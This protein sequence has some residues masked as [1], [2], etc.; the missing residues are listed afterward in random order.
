[1]AAA[2]GGAA[3]LRFYRVTAPFA[4]VVIRR[5]AEPGNLATP[6]TILFTIASPDTLRVTAEVDERDIEGLRTG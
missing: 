2:R 3:A 6:S 5:D 4:G 1:E